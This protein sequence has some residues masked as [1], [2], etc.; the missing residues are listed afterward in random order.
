LNSPA[1]ARHERTVFRLQNRKPLEWIARSLPIGQSIPAANETKHQD[2]FIDPSIF[3]AFF[4]QIPAM[5]D[6]VRKNEV[7]QP[8]F[9]RVFRSDPCAAK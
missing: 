9:H 6:E 2:S 4:V 1:H 5:H 3:E 8:R 7:V